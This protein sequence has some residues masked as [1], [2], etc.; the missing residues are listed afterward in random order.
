MRAAAVV[1]VKVV[2]WVRESDWP[3]AGLRGAG[4]GGIAAGDWGGNEGR[5]AVYKG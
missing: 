3:G 2:Y 1:E 5:G 4:S